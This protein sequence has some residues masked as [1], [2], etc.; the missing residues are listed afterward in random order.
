M[1]TAF[2]SAWSPSE[3]ENEMWTS[4]FRNTLTV[5]GRESVPI[6]MVIEKMMEYPFNLFVAHIFVCH[7]PA[8]GTDRSPTTAKMTKVLVS[9][10]EAGHPAGIPTLLLSRI[11]NILS[12]SYPQAELLYPSLDV[13]Q[14]L[15]N[16]VK[17]CPT[18][19]LEDLLSGLSN[20]LC[21][22]IRDESEMMLDEE[23]ND[24]V[25]ISFL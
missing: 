1:M 5:A 22:W 4:L 12:T 2:I 6:N 20:S 7:S 21:A 11:D 3:Y 15:T 18:T 14:E 16:V 9:H 25:R 10:I 17:T 19:V 13:I 24:V 8:H 23:Y